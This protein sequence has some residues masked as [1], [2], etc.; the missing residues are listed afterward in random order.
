MKLIGYRDGMC[1]V[2]T[3]NGEELMDHAEY[4]ELV[5]PTPV[6]PPK[7]RPRGSDTEEVPADVSPEPNAEDSLADGS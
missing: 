1:I 6:A 5:N 2:N 4:L 7:R 3:G